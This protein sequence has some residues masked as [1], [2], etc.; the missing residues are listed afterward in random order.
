VQGFGCAPHLLAGFVGNRIIAVGQNTGNR[1][2]RKLAVLR[3]IAQGGA[4]TWG[5]I[6]HGM[7][8]FFVTTP[9]RGERIWFIIAAEAEICQ[10]TGP[11]NRVCDY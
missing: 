3:H 1:G 9:E 6:G 11:K 4:F 2:Q 7:T 8:S 5:L 10:W